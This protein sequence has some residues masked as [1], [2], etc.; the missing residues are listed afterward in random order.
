MAVPGFP[1]TTLFLLAFALDSDSVP[2]S[3]L[4]LPQSTPLP[5]GDPFHLLSLKSIDR[6]VSLLPYITAARPSS[7]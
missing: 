7:D 1:A 2:S 6:H 3:N 5:S 4:N